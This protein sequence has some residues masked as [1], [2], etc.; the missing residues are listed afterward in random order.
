M[1]QS[2]LM[3]SA[4]EARTLDERLRRQ[5]E[6]F[7][8]QDYLVDSAWSLLRT[9]ESA[10]HAGRALDAEGSDFDDPVSARRMIQRLTEDGY[11]ERRSDPFDARREMAILSPLARLRMADVFE[12]AAIDF[13]AR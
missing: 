4:F 2:R 12:G 10:G 8:N 9:L 3:L 5:R 1:A 6:R 11:V 7:F 13:N